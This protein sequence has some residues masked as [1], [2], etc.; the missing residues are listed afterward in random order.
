MS[1]GPS[2]LATTTEIA[3]V[4]GVEVDRNGLDVLDEVE[5]LELLASHAF[6]RVAITSGALP[7]ILPVNYHMVGHHILFRTGQGTKLDAAT[8][9]AVVA[10]EVDHIDPV[11]HTGWSVLAVGIARDLTDVLEQM[12]FDLSLIPRWAPGSDGRVVVVVPELLSGR[13]IVHAHEGVVGQLAPG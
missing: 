11:E 1:S 9:N 5:C 12:T 4:H 8:R 10:F 6:G 2:A 3:H 13:R 7:A